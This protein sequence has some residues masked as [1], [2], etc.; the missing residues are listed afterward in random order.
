LAKG[1]KSLCHFLGAYLFIMTV[2]HLQKRSSK[3]NVNKYFTY[4]MFTLRQA[5]FH[6]PP[7]TTT[8]QECYVLVLL[9]VVFHNFGQV[10]G[11]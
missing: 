4:D 7:T 6:Q 10:T 11:P 8:H 2:G 5:V 3:L 1:E 9:P